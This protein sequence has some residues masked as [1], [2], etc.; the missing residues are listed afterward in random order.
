MEADRS[1]LGEE[2]ILLALDDVKGTV[3]FSSSQALGYALA[4]AAL[5]DLTLRGRLQS[6]GKNLIV[7]NTAPT[8]DDVLDEAL[9]KIAAS[10]RPRNAGHWVSSLSIRKHQQRLE[11]RLVRRGVLRRE[12]HRFLGI[13][14]SDRYPEQDRSSEQATRERIR[15]VVLAV[16][17]ADPRTTTLISLAQ[18]T[19]ILERLFRRD[20]RK[21]ARQRVKQITEGEVLGKAVKETVDSINAAIAAGAVVGA[22]SSAAVSS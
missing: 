8:G 17:E 10:K 19:E 6:D 14:P 11:D 18:A 12:E 13:F 4:G 2:L 16:D 15:R 20:E 5:M 9:N 21:I 7:I 3:S 22:S 1:T